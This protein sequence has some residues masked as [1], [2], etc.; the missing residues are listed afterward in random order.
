VSVGCSTGEPATDAATADEPASS[1]APVR[2]PLGPAEHVFTLPVPAP[3]DALPPG[4]S[5]TP[6]WSRRFPTWTS[7]LSTA[8]FSALD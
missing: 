3:S 4:L 2:S 1:E 6:T 8:P 5:T 7:P